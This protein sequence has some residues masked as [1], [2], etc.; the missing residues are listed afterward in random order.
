MLTRH[1][2]PVA[3]IHV[4]NTAFDRDDVDGRDNPD[5]T[6]SAR[7][8]SSAWLRAR[9]LVEAV[10]IHAYP[11]DIAMQHRALPATDHHDPRHRR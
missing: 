2:R 10:A 8:D 4:L 3:S 9:D 1:A 5:M 11:C 6:G 7:Y